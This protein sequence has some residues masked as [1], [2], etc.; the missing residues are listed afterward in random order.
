ML[1]PWRYSG[2]RNRIA[3]FIGIIPAGGV[4]TAGLAAIEFFVPCGRNLIVCSDR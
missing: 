3:I 4:E 2:Y 1:Q